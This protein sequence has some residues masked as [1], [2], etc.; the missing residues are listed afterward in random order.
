MLS[1]SLTRGIQENLQCLA[2]VSA[3]A[4][5]CLLS[6]DRLRG[7]QWPVARPVRISPL[8]PSLHSL[9]E[10]FM[11]SFDTPVSPPHWRIDNPQASERGAPPQATPPRGSPANGVKLW[12]GLATVPPNHHQSVGDQRKDRSSGRVGGEQLCETE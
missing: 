8:T 4:R 6:A 7:A 11:V 5:C 3:A 12:A 2:Q 9:I 10:L 1:R